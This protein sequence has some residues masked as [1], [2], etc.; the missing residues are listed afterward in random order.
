MI[1][2]RNAKTDIFKN[3]KSKTCTA[4]EPAM[5]IIMDIPGGMMI[6]SANNVFDEK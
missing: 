1:N 5:I 3:L 4:S 6:R 2:F